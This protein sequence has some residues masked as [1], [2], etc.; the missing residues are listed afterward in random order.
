MWGFIPANQKCIDVPPGTGVDDCGPPVQE[1][2][3]YE[4]YT[5]GKCVNGLCELDDTS[6]PVYP[7]LAFK[8]VTRYYPA[9]C[10]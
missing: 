7:P 2:V 9:G 10:Q 4:M 6:V 8:T 3:G 5:G 1:S